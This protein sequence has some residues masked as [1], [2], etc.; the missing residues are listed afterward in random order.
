MIMF[1]VDR[2]QYHFIVSQIDFLSIYHSIEFGVIVLP[3]LKHLVKHCVEIS[4]EC[5]NVS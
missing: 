4:I 2:N 3:F 5:K 1:N